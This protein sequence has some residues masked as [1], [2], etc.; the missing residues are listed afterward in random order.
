MVA[1]M[2]VGHR[3]TYQLCLAV[4][5]LSMT[6]WTG[7]FLYYGLTGANSGMAAVAIWPGFAAVTSVGAIRSLEHTREE[8]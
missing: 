3:T 1:A 6:I 8:P 2:V 5:G 7:S 4:L